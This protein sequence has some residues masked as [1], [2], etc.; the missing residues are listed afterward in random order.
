[1]T[2]SSG[3]FAH[4]VRP[5]AFSGPI[6]D[7]S[8]AACNTT[9]ATIDATSIRGSATPPLWSRGGKPNTPPERRDRSKAESPIAVSERRFRALIEKSWD[10]VAQISPRGELLYMSPASVRVFGYSFEELRSIDQFALIHPEDVS[11]VAATFA[12]FLVCDG[13][14]RA[15]E[16]RYRHKSGDW[17]WVEG[18]ATNLVNEPS[19]RSIVVNY[20]DVTEKRI[21]DGERDQLLAREQASRIEAEEANRAKDNFLAILGHE[22]RNPI[23]AIDGA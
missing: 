12:D 16:Y 14:T 18:V 10:V 2:A 8:P 15:F 7:S 4:G 21:A 11:R 5:C 6:R 19:V 20:R 23:A 3:S 1:M 13:E 22:L 17:R 9:S